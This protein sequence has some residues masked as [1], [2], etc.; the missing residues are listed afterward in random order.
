MAP[1]HFL[2][3]SCL[4]SIPQGL[5]AHTHAIPLLVDC[6]LALPFLVIFPLMSFLPICTISA[7]Q[8]P[9]SPP[10]CPFHSIGAHPIIFWIPY[11][12]IGRW[13]SSS[14]HSFS[15][16]LSLPLTPTILLVSDSVL[17]LPAYLCTSTYGLVCTHFFTY[18][19][20]TYYSC[21]L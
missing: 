20:P 5:C 21:I 11:F 10:L 14:Y 8:I 19:N 13:L 7:C 16:W 17:P 18:I 12:T 1:I 4:L 3:C 15:L 2:P 9:G 6:T